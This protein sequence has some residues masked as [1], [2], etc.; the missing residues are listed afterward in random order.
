MKANAVP[1]AVGQSHAK[2]IIVGEHAAVFGYPVLAAPLLALTVTAEARP[3]EGPITL[4]TPLYTGRLHAAPAALDGHKALVRAT[5]AKLERPARD[6]ALR[7]RSNIPIARGLGSSAA[8]AASIVRALYRS[9]G[10]QL[11]DAVLFDLMSVAESFAHGYPSG[12]DAAAV[13]AEGLISFRKGMAVESVGLHGPLHFV[14]ADSGV[15]SATR[16]AVDGV[17]RRLALEATDTRARLAM[18][19]RLA[20]EA[21]AAAAQGDACR[22]G[23]AMNDAQEVLQALGVSHYALERLIDA[24]RKAG[25]LGSKLTGGGHGGCVLA[26]AQD[27]EAARHLALVLRSH[28][29]TSTWLASLGGEGSA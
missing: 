29:A 17:R 12:V 11:D 9:S 24:T 28:G 4:D 6:L 26:L 19:G 1:M 10:A 21:K 5:F 14:I 27:R 16:E 25:A 23:D 3:A 8:I 20:E 7:V 15:P 22:L 13:M 2:V 18:L